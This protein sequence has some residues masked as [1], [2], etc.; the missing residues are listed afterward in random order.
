MRLR[1]SRRLALLIVISASS[2]CA[3]CYFPLTQRYYVPSAEGATVANTNCA[4]Y[5]PYAALFFFGENAQRHHLYVYLDRSSLVAIIAPLPSAKIIFDPTLIQVVADG[6]LIPIKSIR[7]RVGK[8]GGVPAIA[9]QG[10]IDID[11][12][13]LIIEV[14]LGISNPLN[15]VAHIPP[16]TVNGVV[17]SVPDVSFDFK[18]R[19]HM[20]PVI[21]NC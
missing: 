8:S 1:L 2:L 11:T 19:T 9:A 14:P 12:N 18:K 5:P 17:N 3:S 13:N 4:G 15:V 16:I 7:Y 6:D 10:P 20:A 21:V